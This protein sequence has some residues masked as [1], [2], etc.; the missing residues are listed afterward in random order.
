MAA[1]T[2]DPKQP[3]SGPKLRITRNYTLPEFL[4]R[5]PHIERIGK[6]LTS[7]SDST[8]L[9]V[10]FGRPG[11]GKTA[12]LRHGAITFAP[13]LVYVYCD[14]NVPAGGLPGGIPLCEL[15]ERR[16]SLLAQEHSFPTFDEFRRIKASHVARHAIASSGSEL[17]DVRL[18]YALE[19][20][21]ATPAIVHIDR[22]NLLEEAELRLLVRLL[23][24]TQAIFFLEFTTNDEALPH[25]AGVALA[26]PKRLELRVEPLALEYADHLFATLPTR[27]IGPLRAQFIASG[28]LRPFDDATL[29]RATTSDGVEL[30]DASEADLIRLTEDRLL[31]LDAANRNVLL[32]IAAHAGPIDRSLLME[33]LATPEVNGRFTIP[34]NIDSVIDL[35]DDKLL[36]IATTVD[37]SCQERVNGT[38]EHHKT[39]VTMRLAFQ[40]FWRDFYRGASAA[41]IFVSDADRCRQLLHQC[42]ALN[43]LTGIAATLEEIGRKGIASRNPK[44]IVSYLKHVVSRL[45][46]GLSA[47][48]NVGGQKIALQQCKFFYEAGWFDEALECISLVEQRPRSYRFLL[49]ELYCATGF[50]ERGIKL[51][52]SC[53]AE[54]LR[55]APQDRDAELCLKLVRLHG[56]RNSNQLE[57]ARR[58]YWA[59]VQDPRF[60]TLQAYPVLLRYADLCL[61][62]D[63][64]FTNCVKYLEDAIEQ[65][66]RRGMQRDLASA[67]V[68]LAQQIGYTDDLDRAEQLLDRAETIAGSVWLQRSTLLAD[69]AVLSLYR[70]QVAR[71]ALRLL[72]QALVLSWDP[73]DR[74]LIRTNILVW[75]GMAGHLDQVGQIADELGGSIAD[76]SLDG[77]IRR[78]A[79]FN[80]EQVS[81]KRGDYSRADQ[82][83]SAWTGI[84]SGIDEDYWS[85]RRTG[86]VPTGHR[87]QRYQMDFYPVYLAHW[88]MGLV[89]FEAVTD[90]S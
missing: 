21:K 25:Q 10:A 26:G 23:E 7:D 82:F 1:T 87:S 53:L 80:L 77:E 70:R 90:D 48:K 19:I 33:F 74:I 49:A 58:D 89:P 79:F 75:H 17:D 64:E 47:S 37:I 35:L 3:P 4:N 81:R 16:L 31:A 9:I 52:E 13:E 71:D 11:V 36:A 40:Q 42:A 29:F 54:L 14:R 51:A 73:L 59:L 15:L 38:I 55:D 43:D 69:R 67:C 12:L 41:S 34:G 56:L 32:A 60:R 27:F 39:L 5:R 83:R 46:F 30:F 28:S 68:S 20:L 86:R 76:A 66:D 8:R 85:Y 22:G 65:A 61:F 50:Q 78:I 84:R 57:A 45:D 2:G 6:F 88:H 24:T 63:D 44:S 62:G 72:E 18:L